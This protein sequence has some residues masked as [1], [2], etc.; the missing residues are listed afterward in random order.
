ML[1][2]QPGLVPFISHILGVDHIPSPS[3]S[4]SFPLSL[5]SSLPFSPSATLSLSPNL[6]IPAAVMASRFLDFTSEMTILLLSSAVPSAHKVNSAQNGIVTETVRRSAP[7][8]FCPMLADI[9]PSCARRQGERILAA[10]A[11][12]ARHRMSSDALRDYHP[13]TDTTGNSSA[14][15]Y[16]VRR[17]SGSDWKHLLNSLC[18]G[19]C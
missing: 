8:L 19:E 14:S 2:V 16:E 11:A 6:H 10:S 15:A 1:L 7:S 17:Q 9:G 5:P 18:T 3:L 4:L 13:S 12:K